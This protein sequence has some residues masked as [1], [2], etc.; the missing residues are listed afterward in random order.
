MFL[1]YTPEHFKGYTKEILRKDE[2]RRLHISENGINS[3]VVLKNNHH[4]L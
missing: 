1:F 2:I 4:N 3:I